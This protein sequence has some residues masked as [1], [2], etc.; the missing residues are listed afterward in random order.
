M[1]A[2]LEAR[3]EREHA[4]EILGKMRGFGGRGSHLQILEHAHAREDAAPLRRLRDP[5]MRDLVGR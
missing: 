5:Q 4:L 3:E 1:Q 2:L